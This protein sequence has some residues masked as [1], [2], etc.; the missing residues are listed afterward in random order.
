MRKLLLATAAVGALALAAPAANATLISVATGS[1]PTTK[2]TD[3]G[4]GTVD[5]VATV[6]TTSYNVSATGFPSLGFPQPDLDT[7]SVNVST[8]VGGIALTVWVTETGLTSPTGIAPFKSGF[9]SNTWNNNVTSVV[10][11]TYLDPN[12]VAYGTTQMLATTTFT[13][14][15]DS[16]NTTVNS[17][18]L[19]STGYSETAKYVITF[20]TCG[21]GLAACSANDTIDISSN[22]V[23][24][25]AS[26]ALLGVGLLGVGFVARRKRSV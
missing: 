4:T 25:P 6:G 13:V 5:Y 2:L 1:S 14:E 18:S 20:G 7:T 8:T 22:P 12:D 24:E 17:T 19:P 9:T 10:E 3:T 15:S 21:T 23:P 11:T 16:T 26:L